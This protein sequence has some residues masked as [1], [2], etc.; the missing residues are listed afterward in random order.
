MI[1]YYVSIGA[2]LI[3]IIIGAF[4]L[5]KPNKN[6]SCFCHPPQPRPK[7]PPRKNGVVGEPIEWPSK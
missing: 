1:L 5:F 3:L 6:D 4:F 2:I 7:A